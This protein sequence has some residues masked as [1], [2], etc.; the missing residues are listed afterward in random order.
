[1]DGTTRRRLAPHTRLGWLLIAQLALFSMLPQ[2]ASAQQE[3]VGKTTEAANAADRKY[4]WKLLQERDFKTLESEFRERQR[5][6]ESGAATDSEEPLIRAFFTFHSPS[7]A[8]TPLLEEWQKSNPKSYA[9]RVALAFHQAALGSTLRGSKAASQ[10]SEEQMDAMTDAM[11][12][13]GSILGP[14]FDMTAKP[15]ASY[16]LAL[17][18]ARYVGKRESIDAIYQRALKADPKSAYARQRYLLAIDQRWHGS[19]ED[20]AAEIERAR[21]SDLPADTKHFV[22]Y[23]GYMTLAGAHAMMKEPD[24]R[25]RALWAATPECVYANPW[26]DLATLY[27]DT[28]QWK[29]ALDALD[30]YLALKPDQ[31]WAIRRLAFAHERLAE[32]PVALELYKKAAEQ[33]DAYAQNA[34]GWQLFTGDH[35]TRNLEEAIRW[36]RSAADKGDANAKVNLEQALRQVPTQPSDKL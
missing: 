11:V 31:P 34:Y 10:T 5:R 23:Q 26:Q 4:L 9:A 29:K 2:V 24:L 30:K 12:K 19:A 32:W 21:N 16:V 25:E 20:V 36:F 18:I 28:G 14:S 3:C 33:G 7:A 17:E 22:A 8:I 35:T 13:A 15:I 6:Y 27:N 1:M